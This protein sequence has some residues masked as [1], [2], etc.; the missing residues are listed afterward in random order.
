MHAA[1]HRRPIADRLR[2]WHEVEHVADDIRGA[3]R[4]MDCGV[5]F[6]TRGCPLGN[7][8]PDFADAV[9][10]GRWHDAYKKLPRPTTSPTSPAASVPRR[11]KPRACWRSTTPR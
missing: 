9:W 11:A 4:C 8:I 3:G 2:D 6:C 5:P 1:P 7:P 10:H